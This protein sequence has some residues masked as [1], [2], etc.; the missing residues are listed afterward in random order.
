[1]YRTECECI[2]QKSTELILYLLN[3]YYA[4]KITVCYGPFAGQGKH[5]PYLYRPYHL[6][7][8]Q[9]LKRL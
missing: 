2:E 5:S 3:I 7:K 8:K 4:W 9:L 1:M 6:G